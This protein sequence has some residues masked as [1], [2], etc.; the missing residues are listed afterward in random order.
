MNQLSREEEE[1]LVKA[2]ERV[3][4]MQLA[5]RQR[6]AFLER[7]A[8]INVPPSSPTEPMETSNPSSGPMQTTATPPEP[9][10]TVS[11]ESL[12]DTQPVEEVFDLTAEGSSQAFTV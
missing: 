5:E 3:E 6:Q 7:R 1:S 4:R 2:L 8:S 10:Q 9:M 12:P 11:S